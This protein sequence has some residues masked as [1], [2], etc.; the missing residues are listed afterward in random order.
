MDVSSADRGTVVT[1]TD[2]PVGT[3]NALSYGVGIPANENAKAPKDFNPGD[4]LSNSGEYWAGWKSYIFHK[5]EGK[6]DTDGDGTGETNVALHI[7]SDIAYKT[8]EKS[9]D[10]LLV[11][12]ETS[13]ITIDIDMKKSMETD[14]VLFDLETIPQIHAEQGI[15]AALP[16]IDGLVREINN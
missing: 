2:V 12:D 10:L 1:F 7:G 11:K 13:T 15:Q 3:Y 9:I 8:S 14:G 6:L 4:A 5:I 16:L